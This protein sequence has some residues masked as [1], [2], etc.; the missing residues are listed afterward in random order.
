MTDSISRAS[1]RQYEYKLLNDRLNYYVNERRRSYNKNHENRILFCDRKI[2]NIILHNPHLIQ[3]VKRGLYKKK[4]ADKNFLIYLRSII[5][6]G[7]MKNR[8]GYTKPKQKKKTVEQFLE[9]KKTN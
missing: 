7:R 4:I 3:Y 6:N 8:L 9:E 2:T 5:I 1:K